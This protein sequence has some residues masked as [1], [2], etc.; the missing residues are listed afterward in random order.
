MRKLIKKGIKNPAKVPPFLLNKCNELKSNINYKIYRR[1]R[2]IKFQTDLIDKLVSENEEFVLII[3]D[4]CRFDYFKEEYETYLSGDLSLTW[5]AGNRTSKWTPNTWGKKYNLD[6]IAGVSYPVAQEAYEDL[7]GDFD[8]QKTFNE[9][10]HITHRDDIF[11]SITAE[12][13]TE[14]ALYHF[15]N[16]DRIRAVIHH[17]FPHEPYIG[18]TKILPWRVASDELLLKAK[19]FNFHHKIPEY[20]V[21]EGYVMGEDLLT[22]GLTKEEISKLDLEWYHTRERVKDGNITDKELQQ[23]YRDNLRYVLKEVQ[24]LINHL[25]CTV[26]IS[27]DHGEH[28]GEHKNELP[29]YH[30][31][32]YAHPVLREVPWLV[33]DE[34]H[35]DKKDISSINISFEDISGYLADGEKK[36]TREHLRAL[37]YMR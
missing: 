35:K 12:V 5:S 21:R 18:D 3:L 36:D 19:E 9:T 1:R 24:R 33:V 20:A 23:A 29:D 2:G 4:A 37:G 13:V 34:Q 6:Y 14:V 32:D 15:S 30:H 26:V 28:L 7:P 31:P 17:G 25:N 16:S 27:S 10:I 8:P 11:S 22:F